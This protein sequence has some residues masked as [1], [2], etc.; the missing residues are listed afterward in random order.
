[1][2]NFAFLA[3]DFPDIHASALRA[4]TLCLGDARASA[5]AGA[6]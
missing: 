1:M 4:E 3:D 6:F 2:S 5:F